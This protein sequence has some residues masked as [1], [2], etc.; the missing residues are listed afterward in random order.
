MYEARR[1][2]I[3]NLILLAMS[4]IVFP[5]VV[6]GLAR[7]IW[8]ASQ[9][10][11][12]C[13]QDDEK[14]IWAR[15]PDCS[16]TE[17]PVEARRPI[18]WNFD[19][20]GQRNIV[21]CNVPAEKGALRIAAIGNSFTEGAMVGVDEIYINVAAKILEGAGRR[22]RV[23]NFS[24]TGW[25]PRQFFERLPD[26]LLTKPDVV[27]VGLLPNSL[28]EGPSLENVAHMREAVRRVG[29]AEMRRMQQ[30]RWFNDFS[31][32]EATMRTL[33][34]S[35][36]AMIVLQHYLFQIDGLY[37]AL[38]RSRGETGDYLASDLAPV[39]HTRVRNVIA[40]LREMKAR[41]EQ[42]G[43]RFMV[44]YIP[45]RIQAVMLGIPDLSPMYD[46]FS[47]GNLL[48]ADAPDIDFVDFMETLK[49]QPS[50]SALYYP[51]DGH[52]TARGQ[53]LLGEALARRIAGR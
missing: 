18:Q 48:K 34:D 28:F 23:W 39:W 21:P 49:V 53:H 5:L 47:L 12:T 43:A 51:W 3:A 7:I 25:D 31:S 2:L 10:D 30:W 13:F 14:T 45:Q 41:T 4:V 20:C 38:Y 37:F 1:G 17:R 8:P 36:R 33:V 40:L 50:A 27:V 9:A 32:L 52:L 24:V 22:A 42:S 19:E 29:A 6:E 15:R 44:V 26:A 35:S 46:P 16:E 11:F